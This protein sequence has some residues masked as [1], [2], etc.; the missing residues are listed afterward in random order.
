VAK[1]IERQDHILCLADNW[2]PVKVWLGNA[3]TRAGDGNDTDE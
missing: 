1:R 3:C 2:N